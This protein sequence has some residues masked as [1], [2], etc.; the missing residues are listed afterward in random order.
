VGA[1]SVVWW[2]ASGTCVCRGRRPRSGAQRNKC[3]WGTT[4]R[5]ACTSSIRADRVVRPYAR[6]LPVFPWK[7]TKP[8]PC[9]VTVSL[10]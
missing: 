1:L 8:P 9:P 5:Q 3:P 10:Y 7:K 2:T 4:P 6:P